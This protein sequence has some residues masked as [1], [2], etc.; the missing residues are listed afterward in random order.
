[1]NDQL[2]VS[3]ILFLVCSLYFQVEVTLHSPFTFLIG[4]PLPQILVFDIF[5]RIALPEKHKETKKHEL[6][7]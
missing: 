1:M 2:A 3:Q 4:I 6:C 7:A 5:S